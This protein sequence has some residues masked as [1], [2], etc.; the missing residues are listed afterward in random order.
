MNIAP[1]TRHYSACFDAVAETS[2]TTTM[3]ASVATVA[4]EVLS[5]VCE[6]EPLVGS[7]IKAAV[8]VGMLGFTALLKG[9]AMWT[10]EKN[11]PGTLSHRI[12]QSQKASQ[13]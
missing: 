3:I 1:L 6:K 8:L 11:T 2:L 10:S 13:A 4:D 7:N 9:A 12:A 5:M